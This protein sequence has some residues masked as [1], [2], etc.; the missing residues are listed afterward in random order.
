MSDSDSSEEGFST[1]RFRAY[2]KTLRSQ[3]DEQIQTLES[4]VEPTDAISQSHPL[5][6]A[7]Q[8]F[9][10]MPEASIS[11]MF[12][13]LLKRWKEEGRIGISGKTIRLTE[14]EATLLQKAPG[15]IT[16]PSILRALASL[17]I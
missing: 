12:L 13:L 9:F 14:A 15:K 4:Y 2:L 3:L 16:F 5:T 11:T 6:P 1:A 17:H 8:D 10:Q 7:A